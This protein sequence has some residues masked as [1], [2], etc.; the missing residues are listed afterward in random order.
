MR[1]LI[2]GDING[3]HDLAEPLVTDGCEVI[4]S[5]AGWIR[6]PA[7]I[8]GKVRV[9][10]FGGV[11]GL[12]AWPVDNGIDRV[13][14][15]TCPFTERI[16]TNAVAA[17][18]STGTSLLRVSRPSW[19]SHPL[20]DT[21]TWV[22][23]HDDMPREAAEYEKVLLMIGKQS[24][25]HYRNL[26]DVA[27]R[28][29]ELP[30]EPLSG[31]WRLLLERSP[32]TVDFEKELLRDLGVDVLVIKDSGGSLVE[33]KLT[34]ATDLG[35]QAIMV[36]RILVPKDVPQMATPRKVLVRVSKVSA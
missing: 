31:S 27:A 19:T 35:V 28:A 18:R 32:L 9:G 20:V 17:C 3:G 14:D 11:N 25:D 2:L 5:L 16:S 6:K 10:G 26:P 24:L 1:T 30:K 4:T 33:A 29:V 23:S 36:H 7:R 8:A 22:A 34:A 13:V 21:W 12:A 15:A